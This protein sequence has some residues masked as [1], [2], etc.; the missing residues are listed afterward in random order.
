MKLRIC[1]FI[2]RQFDKKFFFLY[3]WIPAG[4]NKTFYLN[5]ETFLI[6]PRIRNHHWT[7]LFIISLALNLQRITP[8][9][10]TLQSTK[11]DL[12]LQFSLLLM[13]MGLIRFTVW[14]GYIFGSKVKDFIFYFLFFSNR[15]L[16]WGVI[17]FTRTYKFLQ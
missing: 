2:Y 17:S 1:G 6:S 7:D 9:W 3:S 13:W 8:L 5:F 10:Q 12:F 4:V 14:I 15:A 16:L 11:N